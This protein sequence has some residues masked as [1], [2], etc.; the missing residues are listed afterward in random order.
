MIKGK[1]LDK[2]LMKAFNRTVFDLSSSAAYEMALINPESSITINNVYV[3]WEEASSA[4]A[5]VAI[6]IG[7]TTTGAQYFTATSSVSQGA[8]TVQT[9]STGSMVLATVPAGTPVYLNHAGSKSGAGTCFVVISY[10]IN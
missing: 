2:Q 9:F 5:G 4:D 1:N 3:V 10:T 6:N 8:G 7:N